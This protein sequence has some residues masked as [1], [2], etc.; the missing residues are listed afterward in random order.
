VK[1]LKYYFYRLLAEVNNPRREYLRALKK[2]IFG[3]AYSLSHHAV[4]TQSADLTTY[5]VDFD[6]FPYSFNICEL[7]LLAEVKTRREK[8]LGYRIVFNLE[9]PE[10]RVLNEL[11]GVANPASE[12]S[13]RR[14]FWNQILGALALSPS[15]KDFVILS[16]RSAYRRLNW[17]PSEPKMYNEFFHKQPP[18][19]FE[20]YTLP[21]NELNLGSLGAPKVIVELAEEFFSKR[22]SKGMRVT[23]VLRKQTWDVTRN[24][25]LNEW[26][27]AALELQSRGACVTI[28]PDSDHPFSEDLAS[29]ESLV[30]RDACWDVK[31]RMA[32]YE[33]SDIVCGTHG[34]ALALGSFSKFTRVIA[35]NRYPEG[36]VVNKPAMTSRLA[37]RPGRLAG[38][39]LPFYKDK[40]YVEPDTSD[41]ILMKIEEF[42]TEVN[43]MIH[44]R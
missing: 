17:N 44:K 19:L 21:E 16:D 20:L 10:K 25:N 26:K 8:Q 35:M 39:H 23:L 2:R 31:L 42:L 32:I 27:K 13:N 24:S 6:S 36:S 30:F 11:K 43:M 18:D 38:R 5:I 34:G 15:L 41:N 22:S 37:L 33:R 3:M 4:K 9:S 29:V 12:E 40:S 1:T 14:K 28:I 7:L